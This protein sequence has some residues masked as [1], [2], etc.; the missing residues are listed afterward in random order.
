MIQQ[1]I[2]LNNFSKWIRCLRVTIRLL[3]TA[4]DKT[5]SHK[6]MKVLPPKKKFCSAFQDLNTS[7]LISQEFFKLRFKNVQCGFPWATTIQF[8]AFRLSPWYR[9][10]L[11]YRCTR[12]SVQYALHLQY[13]QTSLILLFDGTGVSGVQCTVSSN[14]LDIAILRYRCTLYCTVSSNIFDLAILRYRCIRC[15]LYSIFKLAW[16]C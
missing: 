14:F 1:S 15:T 12:C 13:L 3:S 5:V 10:I 2:K 4:L 6:W 7:F 9:F 8:Y 11:W 16:Y